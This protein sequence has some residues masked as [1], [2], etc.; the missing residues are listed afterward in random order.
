[1][2]TNRVAGTLRGMHLQ[3]DPFGETKFVR[4]TRGRIFDVAV[5]ARTGSPG[6]G[7]WVGV[8]LDVGGGLGLVVPP[9]V[10]HGFVTL[11]DDSEVSYQ[12]SVPYRPEA[13]SGFRWD[14]P[15]VG[16]AWPC[17]PRVMS[18]R[19]RELPPLSRLIAG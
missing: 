5:D 13:S 19:D 3:R 6:F 16:I 8:E 9:G 2:S 1:M 10:A 7:R 12:I 4:C 11:A 14:D 18:D 17:P 15:E